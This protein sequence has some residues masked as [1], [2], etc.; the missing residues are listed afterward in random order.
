MSGWKLKL[1]SAHKKA[2]KS[3]ASL[4]SSVQHPPPLAPTPT[5]RQASTLE[6]N[7]DCSP[8]LTIARSP[9]TPIKSH[10]AS[11]L[12][13][14]LATPAALSPEQLGAS[15]DYFSLTAKLQTLPL[16]LQLKIAALSLLPKGK[17]GVNDLR[18]RR[19]N[20]SAY[21]LVCRDWRHW[22]QE[23]L[24]AWA[25]LV[26]HRSVKLFLR[27]VLAR[28][29]LASITRVIVV[30]G[31]K[32]DPGLEKRDSKLL[33]DVLAVC[34]R[35]KTLVIRSVDHVSCA[36]L[37][38]ARALESL[39]IEFVTYKHRSNSPVALFLPSLRRLTISL[40]TP[41]A[42][43][44]TAQK[45]AVPLVPLPSITCITSEGLFFQP[46]Y[47]EYASWEGRVNLATHEFSFPAQQIRVLSL[48]PLDHGSKEGLA[49]LTGLRALN[50]ML[51][52]RIE[53]HE[54][55]LFSW[56]SAPLKVIRFDIADP[57]KLLTVQSA[58]RWAMLLVEAMGEGVESVRTLERV[59]L[60]RRWRERQDMEQIHRSIEAAC[61]RNKVKLEID[62]EDDTKPRRGN[63]WGLDVKYN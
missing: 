34:H 33:R 58:A 37:G 15:L 42:P 27:A 13:T 57:E 51:A 48:G 1:P 62:W 19:N 8:S 52:E 60:P 39:F 24:F 9:T 54:D 6:T 2:H 5:T 17:S 36:D 55:D 49:K 53:G 23:E 26:T 61:K 31:A 7:T 41:D 25:Q 18:R 3:T 59:I 45:H 16:H 63:F 11:P 29:D 28:K 47:R 56:F 12:A 35:T 38:G 21:S 20:L 44:P 50:I 10:P 30:H 46:P 14:P 40:A 22:A 32:K 43:S 4:S